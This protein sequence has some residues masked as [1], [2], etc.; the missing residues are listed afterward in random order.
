MLKD[1]ESVALQIYLASVTV[2]GQHG[3]SQRTEFSVPLLSLGQDVIARVAFDSWE[4]A[5]IRGKE[6]PFFLAFITGGQTND[7]LGPHLDI[8][9][10]DYLNQLKTKETNF[11]AK[12]IWTVLSERVLTNVPVESIDNKDLSYETYSI[13]DALQDLKT[14]HEAWDK[15]QDRNQLWT[16]IRV[17]NK[18][19]NI[20]DNAA[21]QAFN[22]VGTIFLA[23]KNYHEAKEAF[24]QATSAFGRA[25]LFNDS[26]QSSA[27]AGKCAF[28]L[29]NLDEAIEFLQGG[30]LWVKG[31]DKLASINFDMASALHAKERFEES[32]VYFEKAITAATGVDP[33]IAAEYSATYASRLMSH[34]DSVRNK[35]LTLSQDL[36]RR[37]ATQRVSAA[38]LLSKSGNPR[39]AASSLILAGN[40]LLSLKDIREG[41]D[42]LREAADLFIEANDYSS[43]ARA[44]YNGA[45][46]IKDPKSSD[47]LLSRAINLLKEH[48]TEQN[49]HT[50]G[51]L[52][53]EKG[54]IETKRQQIVKSILS[55]EQ[56]SEFLTQAQIKGI[57]LFSIYIQ[58]ANNH[59]KLESFERAA[60][61]FFKAHNSLA[62]APRRG[63]LEDQ[64]Q[65]AF[66]NG[67]ISLRRAS[68]VY[69]N[70]GIV[71]LQNKEEG[72]ALDLFG[73]SIALLVE[74]VRKNRLMHEEEV[75]KTIY[76][77]V[78]ALEL[79]L[80]IFV[81]AESKYRLNVEIS[82]LKNA[83]KSF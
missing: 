3:Q 21:G 45:R 66:L 57:E 23:G 74:W 72:R 52:F 48:E 79:K 44:L 58:L 68:T 78:E 15:T 65:K 42:K 11:V 7:L 33:H 43:A 62:E 53:F 46:N 55:F 19:E 5:D 26:G 10:F 61:S 67:L 69:H 80:G 32:Y 28:Y 20:D 35:N 31:E 13:K 56:S 1:P 37:S 71:A 40:A 30:V 14:A 29:A 25:R 70:A 50:L 17:A 12:E 24:E 39:E 41:C 76:E 54:K 2:F 49:Y 4:D 38:R 22:L 27:L 64:Y 6:R 59:F 73:R 75:K 51:L 8:N 83:M 16:A 81:K 36:I 34:A 60:L 82:R 47:E 77:R 18:L 9:I 63:N